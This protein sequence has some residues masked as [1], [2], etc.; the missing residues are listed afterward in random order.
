MWPFIYLTPNLETTGGHRTPYHVPGKVKRMVKSKIRCCEMS[1]CIVCQQLTKNTANPSLFVHPFTLQVSDVANSFFVCVSHI[2]REPCRSFTR[3]NH[4]ACKR[5]CKSVCLLGR[6]RGG[7]GVFPKACPVFS[8]AFFY[9][10]ENNNMTAIYYYFQS[11][12][13][14]LTGDG[15]LFYQVMQYR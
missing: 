4:W 10:W 2:N 8:F 13:C 6:G 15:L 11:Y 1:S 9:P 3:K 7:G 5:Y 14:L 12:H